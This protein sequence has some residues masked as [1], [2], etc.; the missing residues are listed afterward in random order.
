MLR[1][2]EARWEDFRINCAEYG[3]I[4]NDQE[5]ALIRQY[6]QDD[7]LSDVFLQLQVWLSNREITIETSNRRYS[8]ISTDGEELEV[9]Y[10]LIINGLI[11]KC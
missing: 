1:I 10:D 2:I 3:F 4:L 8:G 7:E 6:D 5:N 11:E 9:L